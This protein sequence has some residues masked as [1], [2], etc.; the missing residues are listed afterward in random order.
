MSKEEIAASHGRSQN[1]AVNEVSNGVPYI[2]SNGDIVEGEEMALNVIND[3]N[4]ARR[5]CTEVP[6][7][8]AVFAPFSR[9]I[10]PPECLS[11]IVNSATR[12]NVDSHHM[13]LADWIASVSPSMPP[14]TSGATILMYGVLSGDAALVRLAVELGADAQSSE[15]LKSTVARA[16]MMRH[17]CPPVLAACAAGRLPILEYLCTEGC[18]T[19]MVSDRW[20]RTLLHAAAAVVH[21]DVIRWL[22]DH[23]EIG[24][25]TVDKDA[26]RAVDYLPPTAS[27]D[28]YQQLLP[29]S[30]PRCSFSSFRGERAPILQW[31]HCGGTQPCSCPDAFFERWYMDRANTSWLPVEVALSIKS[32]KL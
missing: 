10:P 3:P 27:K 20:G 22:V 28:L 30:V 29:V 19:P 8:F 7:D 9:T 17:G 21:A 5:F 6:L 11:E 16:H 31:C 13:A 14:T 25:N 2:P 4:V 12:A 23:T 32:M 24:R 18:A 1:R 15:F 26:R